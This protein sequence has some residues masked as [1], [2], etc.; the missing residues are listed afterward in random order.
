VR[1]ERDYVR[2]DDTVWLMVDGRLAIEPVSIVFQDGD[3]A[4]ID[5]GLDADDRV[6]TTR[7]A[8]VKEGLRLR[9]EDDRTGASGDG[10]E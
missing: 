8:T 7:L 2:E 3:Y 6:V 4:Y 1:I 9:V 5:D 10:G